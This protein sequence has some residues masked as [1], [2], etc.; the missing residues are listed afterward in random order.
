MLTLRLS[1]GN[2]KHASILTQPNFRLVPWPR[3]AL[4]MNGVENELVVNEERF[5]AI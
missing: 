5:E 4:A 2:L 1:L 3:E